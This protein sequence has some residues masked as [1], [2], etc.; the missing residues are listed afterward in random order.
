MNRDTSMYIALC[1]PYMEAD[2]IADKI[3]ANLPEETIRV[4]EYNK[5][6]DL[7]ALSGLAIYDAIWVAFPGALGMETVISMREHCPHTPIVWMSE[8][9]HF[10]WACVNWHLAMLLI[11]DSPAEDFRIAV[12]NSKTLKERRRRRC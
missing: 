8:D 1:A 3:C 7:L 12:E 5:T 9:E 4:D 6:S 2:L 10:G 11:P